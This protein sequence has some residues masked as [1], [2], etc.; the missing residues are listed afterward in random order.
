MS[1]KNGV[2]RNVY[3]VGC[4]VGERGRILNHLIGN[5]GQMADKGWNWT[6]GV[7]Q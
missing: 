1:D 6:T 2:L 7:Q 3:Y 4:Y 5:A